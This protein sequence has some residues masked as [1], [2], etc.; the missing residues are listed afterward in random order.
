MN[1]HLMLGKRSSFL[2]LS[3]VENAYSRAWYLVS[4][5]PF[6]RLLQSTDSRGA[7]WKNLDGVFQQRVRNTAVLA[8]PLEVGSII[9]SAVEYDLCKQAVQVRMSQM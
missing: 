4:Y 9:G 1:Q 7:D 6:G 2:N 5:R 8:A 3:Q